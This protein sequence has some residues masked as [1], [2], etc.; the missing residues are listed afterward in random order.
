MVRIQQ[1]LL[2][3]V[4][5]EEE[6]VR[7]MVMSLEETVASHIRAQFLRRVALHRREPPESMGWRV[8]LV[9][10]ETVQAA[11]VLPQQP[12]VQEVM[13]AFRVGV[14]EEAVVLLRPGQRPQAA[15]EPWAL[16]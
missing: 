1:P 11:A 13:V 6:K 3:A 9:N 16:L 12:P 15:T 10:V 2:A 5:R 4:G 7:L 8:Y 14:E